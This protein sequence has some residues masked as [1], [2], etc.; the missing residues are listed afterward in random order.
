MLLTVPP[1]SGS[2]T[3]LGVRRGFEV[4]F[5]EAR[6]TRRWLRGH[7][8]AREGGS[9][10]SVSYRI[11]LAEDWATRSVE[12]TSSTPAGE[13]RTSLSRAPGGH[14]IVDGVARPDLDDC[15]DVDFE[16]SGVTNTLP[17]HRIP[18][19]PGAPVQVPAALV[20]ADDLRAERIDQTYT[21]LARP[22]D[23]L[24]FSYASPTFGFEC[25]LTF[26]SA[27]LTLDYPGIA[28]R[29]S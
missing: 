23:E 8:T 29:D 24:R 25:E 18:F 6:D 1:R 9:L 3:H 12:A 28:I 27:G 14:W 22:S 11:G 16:S 20:R 7:T 15:V 4:V 26:D 10:W 21:L 2:W 17:V 19:E 5:F 13:R